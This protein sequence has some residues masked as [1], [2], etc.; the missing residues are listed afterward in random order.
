M[1]AL[2][3]R[4]M[5][6]RVVKAM[7][8]FTGTQVLTIIC[9]IIRNKL[10]ALWVGQAG[11]GILAIFSAAVELLSSI[12]QMG[13][14]TAAVRLTGSADGYN[15]VLRMCRII[16]RLSMMLAGVS[17]AVCLVLSPVL[18]MVTFGD[19]DHTWQFAAL[20]V[21]LIFNTL[22]A[23]RQGMLQGL[24]RIGDIARASLAGT[25]V[26]L[27][28]SVP[29]IYF[30]GKESIIPLLI[31]YSTVTAIAFLVP[32]RM[33]VADSGSG[34]VTRREFLHESRDILRFGLFITLASGVVWL[35]EYVFL[36]WLRHEAGESM[37]GL[38]QAGHALSV[39]YIGLIF[40]AIAMEFYPRISSVAG[41]SR[42]LSVFASHEAGLIL[43][44]AAPAA[45]VFILLVP[46][47]IEL[48]YSREFLQATDFVRI[49]VPGTML[50]C[51]AW[52][53]GFVIL[54]RGDGRVYLFTESMSTIVSLALN[55]FFYGRYGLTGLGVAFV[56]TYAV[57]TPLVWLIA[58]NLYGIRL[59][60]RVG[61]LLAGSLALTCAVSAIMTI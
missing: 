46:W 42:R 34:S 14:R 2:T 47:V 32:K 21:I 40:T 59:N 51:V 25:I 53:L 57:Y 58:R 5:S 16:G 20:S 8:L 35:G 9:S 39:K 7:S 15:G 44:M 37:V 36:A 41:S 6:R 19:S 52:C 3:V 27:G 22:V 54:S 55:I 50:R 23:A 11:I 28:I 38:Y 49:A 18:S 33:S 1:G 56:C 43:K 24:G 4:G 26:S 45:V 61:L 10:I 12:G 13:L 60:G 48:L 30:L 31:T 29:L 17:G